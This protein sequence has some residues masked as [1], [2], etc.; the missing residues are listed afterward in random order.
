VVLK[1]VAL[2]EREENIISTLGEQHEQSSRSKGDNVSGMLTNMC[3]TGLRL[4]VE[5]QKYGR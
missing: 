4:W 3:S 5:V 1:K 2:K